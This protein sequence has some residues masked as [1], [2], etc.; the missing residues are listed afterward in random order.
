MPSG[1][2]TEE[3]SN[4]ITSKSACLYSLRASPS[5]QTSPR[6]NR[7]A[8]SPIRRRCGNG[9]DRPE[10][11]GDDRFFVVVV[12]AFSSSTP[13]IKHVLDAS[14]SFFACTDFV[15]LRSRGSNI[16]LALIFSQFPSSPQPQR[17]HLTRPHIHLPQPHHSNQKRNAKTHPVISSSSILRGLC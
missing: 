6:R 11:V 14:S 1:G 7:E 16:R 2:G 5:I 15:F 13:T 8:N 9:L 4:S 17:R 3:R 12:V 10:R